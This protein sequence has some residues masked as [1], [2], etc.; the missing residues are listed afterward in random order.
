MK[1]TKAESKKPWMR[2]KLIMKM[3]FTKREQK[4]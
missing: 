2:V 3:I 4:K 1:Y